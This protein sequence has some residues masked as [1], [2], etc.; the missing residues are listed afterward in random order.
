MGRDVI[1][2]SSL[3]MSANHHR[4]VVSDTARFLIGLFV[5]LALLG[6]FQILIHL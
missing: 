3:T 5:A 4:A 2:C 1:V 6:L